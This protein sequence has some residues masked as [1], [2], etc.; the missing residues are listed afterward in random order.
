MENNPMTYAE[1][2]RAR[3]AALRARR[4]YPGVV[5]EVLSSELLTWAEFGYRFG[6]G[7]TM[8]LMRELERQEPPR[9]TLATARAI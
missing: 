2:T 1:K 5:G 8:A 7:R 9:M 4:L 3:A 6:F